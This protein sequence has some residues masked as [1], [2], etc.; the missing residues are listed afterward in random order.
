MT[1]LEHLTLIIDLNKVTFP[2]Q[3]KTMELFKKTVRRLKDLEDCRSRVNNLCLNKSFPEDGV[4]AQCV[5][6]IDVL[7]AL[8]TPDR[9]DA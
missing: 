8:I 9:D 6:S 1:L 3:P 4:G 5:L 2:D 7:E